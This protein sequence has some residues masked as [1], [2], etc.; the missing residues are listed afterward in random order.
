[1]SAYRLDSAATEN[2]TKELLLRVRDHYLR[3][4]VSRDTAL[5]VLNAAAIVVATVIAA[6]R[7]CGDENSASTFFDVALRQQLQVDAP[8]DLPFRI[9]P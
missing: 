5:E 3:R 6:A 4:P 2:L 9:W 1:M 8:G 7:A